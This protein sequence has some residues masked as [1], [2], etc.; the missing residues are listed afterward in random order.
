MD[1]RDKLDAVLKLLADGSNAKIKYSVP[2]SVLSSNEIINFLKSDTTNP[3]ELDDYELKLLLKKLLDDKY[4]ET[5]IRE[6]TEENVFTIRFEGHSFIL[7]GGYNG[8][9]LSKNMQNIR[10][11]NLEKNQKVHRVALTVLTSL[12]AVGTLVAAWY[13]GQEIWLFYHPFSCR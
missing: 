1:P 5:G 10:L 7:D 8:Q 6:N 9:Y 11:A 4:I 13:Y 12:I 3:I 2:I